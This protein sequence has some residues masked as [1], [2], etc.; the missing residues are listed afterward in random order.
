VVTLKKKF[1]I[2]KLKRLLKIIAAFSLLVI[3]F[4]WSWAVVFFALL[5]LNIKTLY[6]ALLGK[7]PLD[8]PENSFEKPESLTYKRSGN[9]NLKLD[10]FYPRGS[11]S[12]APEGYPVVFFAHG[13]GW[14]SGFRKQANN[15]S[16][17][18]YLA[19]RGFAVVNIDYR[20]GFLPHIDDILKDYSDALNFVRERAEELRLNPEKI[21]LMGLSA[22]GH[23]AL[24]HATYHSYHGNQDEMKGVKCVVAWYAPSDL[25]DLWDDKVESLFARFAVSTTLKGLPAR[26]KGGYIRYSPIAWV[27]ERMV[28]VFLV[29]GSSDKVVPVNSSVK[30][31][32][33]LLEYHVEAYLEVYN[34]AD[35]AFEFELKTSKTIQLIEKT[36]RFLRSHL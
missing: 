34:R 20:F 16:W 2:A 3:G 18:K 15:I 33:K 32:K 26:D 35:H 8:V 6:H 4:A 11:S 23:L 24:Q 27:S 7:L 31:F 14:I 25:M 28:P 36:V 10:I 9:T 17:C 1:S 29:H 12:P 5:A 13:G 19:S 30:F 22:G 21:A